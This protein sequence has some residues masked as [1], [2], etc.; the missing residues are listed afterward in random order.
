MVSEFFNVKL[1]ITQHMNERLGKKEGVT[2]G[3]IS[4]AVNSMNMKEYFATSA[5]QSGIL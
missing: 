4:S 5:G 2:F 1:Y 3:K